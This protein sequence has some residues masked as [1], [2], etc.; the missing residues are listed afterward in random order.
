MSNDKYFQ[1]C[2]SNG[3]LVGV[4]DTHNPSGTISLSSNQHSKSDITGYRFPFKPNYFP[5]IVPT[6]QRKRNILEGQV[7]KS[8]TIRYSM[9]LSEPR[10]RRWVAMVI[11]TYSGCVFR[12][13]D[14]FVNVFQLSLEVAAF[15]T[16]ATCAHSYT[17]THTHTHSH[18][19]THTYTYTQTHTHTYPHTQH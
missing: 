16:A 10:K 17:H 8:S 5:L 3:T 1:T 11:A 9:A 7:F 13:S 2:P 19:H 15:T 6:T 14:V 12:C 18:T 4:T